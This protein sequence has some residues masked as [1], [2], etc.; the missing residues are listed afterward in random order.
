MSGVDIVVGLLICVVWWTTIREGTT[1]IVPG[2][3]TL[4]F[5]VIILSGCANQDVTPYVAA[6]HQSDPQLHNDGRDLGC[7]GMKK[8][9]Q[10]SVKG[11]YCWDVEGDNMA[12]VEVEYDLFGEP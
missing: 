4:L 11:G 5:F 7:I 8:R 6:R 1:K 9:G 3:M 2:I 12:E 10:L